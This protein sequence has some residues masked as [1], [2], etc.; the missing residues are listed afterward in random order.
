MKFPRPTQPKLRGPYRG[1][2]YYLYVILD[3]FSRYVVGWML[4]HRESGVLAKRLLS[5]TIEREG[6]V[7]SELI[8]HSDRGPSMKSCEVGQL[9]ATLM[10]GRSFSRPR[11]PDDNPYSESQFKT[12]KYQPEFPERFDGFEHALGHC[13]LFFPWYNNEHRHSGIALLTPADVH[14][15]RSEEV[16]AGRQRVLDIAFEAHPE[17]F[18]KGPPSP[19]LLPQEVAINP[20]KAPVLTEEKLH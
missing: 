18:V 15:G 2:L 9:L 13:R 17:R 4:A 3:I 11:V 8:T 5:E 6:I 19:L 16:L 10:V 12:L 20:P 1:V 14:F 7:A